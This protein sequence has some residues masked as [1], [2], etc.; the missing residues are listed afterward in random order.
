MLKEYGLEDKKAL[1][2]GG[3]T[4]IGRGIALVLAEAGADVAVAARTVKNVE[5]V[6]AEIRGLGK[7][8]I[9]IQCDVSDSEQ[10]NAMVAR[11][12]DELGQVDILVN[13]AGIFGGGPIAPLPEASPSEPTSQN[14][15][16]SDRATP[17]S[18]ELWHRVMDTNVSSVFYACRA[19]GAQMM[20]RRQ[21]KIINVSSKASI[22]AS[23][24]GAP[25][26]TSKAGINMLTKV[27]AIEWGT[28]NVTVNCIIPG[29]FIT[30]MTQEGFNDPAMHRS[31]VE[32]IPLKRLTD[33]RELGLL[34]VYLASP[35]SDWMTGQC[36]ALDGGE[37]AFVN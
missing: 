36:I 4:G 3:G 28:Y 14:D 25:Y 1:V 18:V 16:P 35:A 10:V 29:W 23:P 31:R 8:G 17:L 7:R 11:A 30:P 20:E 37:S 32:G 33:I 12:T 9:A 21:G 26:N 27:L 5:A 19:V 15:P 2:T 6:A 24:F 13:N 22:V 34:A